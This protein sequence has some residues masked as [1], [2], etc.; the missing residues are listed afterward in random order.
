MASDIDKLK[1]KPAIYV[2][3]VKPFNGTNYKQEL[4]IEIEDFNKQIFSKQLETIKYV[5]IDLLMLRDIYL[6]A[7]LLLCNPTEY[8]YV[9]SN[10]KA[11]N[12]RV[13]NDSVLNYFPEIKTITDSDIHAYISNPDN[14]LRLAIAAPPTKLYNE[15]PFIMRII[16]QH[17]SV[18][19]GMAECANL[20]ICINSYPLPYS[21]EVKD[22]HNVLI[23]SMHNKFK[24]QHVSIPLA[25]IDEESLMLNDNPKYGV[26]FVNDL[27]SFLSED[28]R[29]YK[30]FVKYLKYFNTQI[31]SPP[32]I[33][34]TLYEE[35]KLSGKNLSDIFTNTEAVMSLSCNFKYLD[36][37]VS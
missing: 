6:G 37:S 4:G 21:T 23:K 18:L 8:K 26:M 11:Y 28:S 5:Y 20:T 30:S 17:N 35:I 27:N 13:L 7:L 9:V 32:R 3:P 15:I 34:P 24:L 33:D 12:S 29:S 31:F 2:N 19:I 22:M 36:I 14:S 1:S 25:H 16:M 10:L